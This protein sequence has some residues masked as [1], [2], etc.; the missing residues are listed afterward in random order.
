MASRCA[1]PNCSCDPCLCEGEC[2]CG[3]GTKLGELEQ[4]VMDVVWAA[5]EPEVTVREVSDA[6]PVYAYTTIATVLSRLSRKGVLRRR[7]E[8]RV[9]FFAPLGTRSDRAASA[10][11]DALAE[12]GDRGAALERFVSD[13]PAG[14]AA[15]LRRALQ[16]RS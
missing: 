7:V 3:G 4:Q 5:A 11:L 16:S 15:V 8:G 9:A 10:M 13:V 1:N 14:D 12:S 2:K 6:L